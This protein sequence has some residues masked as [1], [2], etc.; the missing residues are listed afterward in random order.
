MVKANYVTVVRQEPRVLLPPGY[1]G[2]NTQPE[3]LC[4]HA[5]LHLINS[6]K[7]IQREREQS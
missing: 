3:S 6:H 7:A 2:I 5:V 1:A 4:T